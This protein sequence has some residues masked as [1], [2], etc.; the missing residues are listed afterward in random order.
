M[1]HWPLPLKPTIVRKCLKRKKKKKTLGQ[2]A[3]RKVGRH[4]VQE[5]CIKKTA[6][7]RIKGCRT[8]TRRAE[9]GLLDL[10]MQR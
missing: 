6:I 7:N 5:T 8:G 1:N 9:S 10:A 4:Q 3:T 2:R